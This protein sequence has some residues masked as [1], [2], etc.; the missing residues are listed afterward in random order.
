V[1]YKTLPGKRW[2]D[3]ADT[4][5]GDIYF[6]MAQGIVVPPMHLA[7]AV[8]AAGTTDAAALGK[9]FVSTVAGLNPSVPVSEMRTM[10]KV[11]SDSVSS[12]RSI[13]WLFVTF[14]GLALLLGVVGIYSLMSYSVSQRTRE[15]GIRMAMGADRRHVLGMVLRRGSLL[16]VAG[17]LLGAGSARALTRLMGGLLYGVR[18]TDA[19]TFLLVSLAVI[20]AA[21]V[22]TYI[23]SNRATKVDPTVALKCE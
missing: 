14:A 7:V 10:D 19:P 15:I 18:P 2:S 17:V 21:M 13:M 11:I 12:S 1:K 5:R 4:V 20:V 3:W 16:T 9:Q 23:P 22:A 6:P 8:R